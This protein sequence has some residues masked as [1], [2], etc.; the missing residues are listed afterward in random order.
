MAQLASLGRITDVLGS[1]K[2]RIVEYPGETGVC[3]Q[4]LGIL[5]GKEAI[6]RSGLSKRDGR[7]N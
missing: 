1:G 5:V 2:F 4:H 6:A 7:P 3:L